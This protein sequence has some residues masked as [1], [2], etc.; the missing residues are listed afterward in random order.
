MQILYRYIFR[1]GLLASSLV[2]TTCCVIASLIN[3]FDILDEVVKHNVGMG[4]VFNFLLVHLM[5]LVSIM[6]ILAGLFT[7]GELNRRLELI[8][9]R[10]A[11][12][13]DF[14]LMRPMVYLAGLVLVILLAAEM[15]YLPGLEKRGDELRAT[16]R[17]GRAVEPLEK[18]FF[19]RLDRTAL[20]AESYIPSERRLTGV[21]LYEFERQNISEYYEAEAMT[22]N[23]VNWTLS[24]GVYRKMD[25]MTLQVLRYEPFDQMPYPAQFS[26]PE[27]VLQA[28]ARNT[29]RAEWMTIPELIVERSFSARQEIHKR[30]AMAIATA[31]GPLVGAWYGMKMQRFNAAR[32]ICIAMIIGFAHR[33]LLDGFQAVGIQVG[34]SWAC[35]ISNIFLAASSG[36]ARFLTASTR[37]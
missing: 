32:A 12:L 15:L 3:L 8:S 18:P 4:T 1:R 16:L 37:A 6:M 33:L 36:M 30:I 20:Q 26:A 27:R 19:I 24:N 10:S 28:A 14:A 13:S 9:M 2:I 29:R 23:G 21:R 7:M 5:E 35:H 34:A 31:L 11:G 17:A 25:P 22:G